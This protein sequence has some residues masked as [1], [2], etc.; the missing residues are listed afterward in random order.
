MFR[1]S[2][3]PRIACLRSTPYLFRPFAVPTLLQSSPMN[4]DKPS[5]W[6][7]RVGQPVAGGRNVVWFPHAGGGCSPLIRLARG[8]PPAVNLYVATLPG[9]EARFADP[10]SSSLDELVG[11]LV[12][13]LPQ[14][15]EPPVLVGH[16]FGALLAFLVARQKPSKRLIV[17]A[18]GSPDLIT[19]RDS[20]VDLD[21]REFA[22]QL[23]RRYGGVP[24]TLRENEEAMRMFLPTVRRDLTLLE[25]YDSSKREVVDV[26]ITALAG[27]DDGR[28]TAAKM[29]NW[30]SFTQ[31]DFRLQ[32]MM[33]DHFF[34]MS[35]FQQVLKIAAE[36]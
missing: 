19:R 21:D 32:M 5:K 1:P 26:P 33:G 2:K 29:Q 15:D 17:M 35:N 12:D 7:R 24:K 28:V 27:T 9:R 34:P 8:N 30:K 23:D 25:S 11:S 13:E 20:I 16:S 6:Y 14:T 22:E 36:C 18:M 3:V 10:M 4:S 31:A